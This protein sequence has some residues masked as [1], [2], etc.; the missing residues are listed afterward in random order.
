MKNK[1]YTQILLS[2][3]I[4]ASLYAMEDQAAKDRQLVAYGQQAGR[5]KS[6]KVEISLLSRSKL[7][8]QKIRSCFGIPTLRTGIAVTTSLT[9]MMLSFGFGHY[10]AAS[11]GHADL[12]ACF[13]ACD[14]NLTVMQT[15]LG[16]TMFNLARSETD[17]SGCLKNLDVTMFNLTSSEEDLSMC[18]KKLALIQDKIWWKNLYLFTYSSTPWAGML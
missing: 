1:I 9:A 10:L 12:N 7:G 5:S 16:E 3:I 11:Q 18:L 8:W 17:F 15:Q 14:Y 4:G 13:S 6:G 2:M